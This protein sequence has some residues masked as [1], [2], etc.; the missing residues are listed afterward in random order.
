MSEKKRFSLRIILIITVSMAVII[1]YGATLALFGMTLVRPV[2]VV[3]G[4]AVF[5]AAS[6]L[7]F[8]RKWAALTGTRNFVIN[9]ICNLV[10]VTGLA[11]ALF[12][13]VNYFGRNKT[14]TVSVRAEVLRVYPETHYRTKRLARNRYT[15]GEPYKVYY[16][17]V[18]LPDGRERKREIP[19]KRYNR[20]VR[21]SHIRH[22]RPD[23]VDLR[24]TPGALGL[25]VIE[26]DSPK[27]PLY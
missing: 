22:T 8:G 10:A 21:S 2:W 14:E 25:T 12:L 26:P 24:L 17:D 4:A 20:Y 9:V 15:R 27:W 5:A 13:G 7:A 23:S 6:C 18:R 16:M 19:L 3:A 1:F 11:M